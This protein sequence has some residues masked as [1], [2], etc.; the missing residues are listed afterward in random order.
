MLVKEFQS[1]QTSHVLPLLFS[2]RDGKNSSA[3][4]L[5][6]LGNNRITAQS[7]TSRKR[8]THYCNSR[9]I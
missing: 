1:L 3:A 8:S 7:S 4:V 5:K 6:G 9:Q 2:E